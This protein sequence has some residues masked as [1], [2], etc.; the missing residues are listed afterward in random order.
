MNIAR[1]LMVGSETLVT[2]AL[3]TRILLPSNLDVSFRLSAEMTIGI[4]AR[5]FVPLLLIGGAGILS[6]VALLT[7]FH[8]LTHHV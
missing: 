4:P 8:T 1:V 5:W 2:V 3:L 6:I 7:F